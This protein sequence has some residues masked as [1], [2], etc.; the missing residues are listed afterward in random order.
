MLRAVGLEIIEP[1]HLPEELRRGQIKFTSEDEKTLLPFSDAK[2]RVVED[3][4]RR[5]LQLVLE[6]CNGVISRAAQL[7]GMHSKN[8]HEK[9]S[10]YGIKTKMSKEQ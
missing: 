8:F 5:Y 2:K 9:M 10:K 6:E 4:E 7:A 3:F 1:E